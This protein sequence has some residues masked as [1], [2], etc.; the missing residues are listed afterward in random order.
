[1]KQKLLILS[2]IV[3]GC[4]LQPI[5]AQEGKNHGLW[6]NIEYSYG[7]G[8]SD[9]GDLYDFSQSNTNL[10]THSLRGII[11]YYINPKFSI[12]FGGG[13]AGYHNPDVNTLPLF[14]D[15]RYF[16]QENSKSVYFYSDLGSSVS[17]DSDKNSGFL[18]ELGVGYKIPISKKI[19]LT[20]AL[21]YNLITY[22]QN[23]YTPSDKRIRNSIFFKIGVNI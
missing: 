3:I 15:F 19:I 6:G 7:L 4:F 14:I 12:G 20:P 22:K 10:Y 18:A 23:Y 17:L 8:L 13:I 16:L 11:G 2:G 1:M 21:G 5:C 9:K